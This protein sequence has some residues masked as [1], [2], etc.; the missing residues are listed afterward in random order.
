VK[1]TVCNKMNRHV[2]NVM[3]FISRTRKEYV[4]L[5]CRIF[6]LWARLVKEKVWITEKPVFCGSALRIQLAKDYYLYPIPSYYC[7][8]RSIVPYVIVNDAP[9]LIDIASHSLGIYDS[10]YK[11]MRR[12]RLY[13]DRRS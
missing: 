2:H 9:V 7:R 12:Y 11:S 3:G 8:N 6:N 13:T 1:Y 5:L 4:R 10:G